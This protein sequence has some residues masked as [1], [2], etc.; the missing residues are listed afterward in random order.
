[1]IEEPKQVFQ[2]LYKAPSSNEQNELPKLPNQ[3]KNQPYF[4]RPDTAQTQLSYGSEPPQFNQPAK[5]PINYG[6]EPP[7]FNQ[8]AKTPLSYGSE[9]PQFNQPAKTSVNYG[10]EP[11]QFN[12]P[13][14]P[15][16]T[17]LQSVKFPNLEDKSKPV[18][19]LQD[20]QYEDMVL[21]LQGPDSRY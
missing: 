17:D 1:M 19:V 3:K 12:Q 6:S 15:F 8:P 5:T 11:P 18:N 21:Q 4:T 16:Q 9:P 14:I 10:S 13:S 2:P 7:Q 20:L